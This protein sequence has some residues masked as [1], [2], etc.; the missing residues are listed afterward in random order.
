MSILGCAYARIKANHICMS[1]NQKSQLHLHVKLVIGC[2]YIACMPYYYM[3][4]ETTVN[5]ADLY[6]PAKSKSISVV[7]GYKIS[8]S[9]MKTSYTCSS[10]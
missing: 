9:W 3:Y 8:R 6:S 10:S 5:M 4:T 2:L 7:A 1:T